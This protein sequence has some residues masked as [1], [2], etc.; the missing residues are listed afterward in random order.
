[1]KR[2]VCIAAVLLLAGLAGGVYWYDT[3]SDTRGETSQWLSRSLDRVVSIHVFIPEGAYTLFVEKGAW[4]ADVPGASWNVRAHA[5]ANR[6]G[7]Y[8]S[9]LADLVP[10]KYIA[11][12]DRSGP[13]GYGLDEPDFKAILDFSGKGG[14]PLVIKFSADETG[15]VFGWNSGNPGMVYE[16]DG[17]VLAR[18]SSSARHF[19][20]RLCLPV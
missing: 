20:G 6:V 1:M 12:V 3:Y 2:I 16:F 7:E 4:E 5:R 19:L 8:I 9:Y 13:I 11:G 14:G 10:N 18:L 17:K 15:R